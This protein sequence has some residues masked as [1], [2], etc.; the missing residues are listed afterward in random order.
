MRYFIR[1]NRD[2]VVMGGI[3][4]VLAT[5]LFS[6]TW[7]ADNT[8]EGKSTDEDIVWAIG[9]PDGLSIEFMAGEREK[10][11]FI[12]EMDNP[13]EKFPGIH[14]GALT[15][16]GEIR[17][18]PYKIIFDLPEDEKWNDSYLFKMDLFYTTGSPSEI[19]IDIN[20]NR[21]IF[22]VHHELKKDLNDGQGNSPLLAKQQLKIP[23]NSEWLKD[24]NNEIA[25]IPLGIGQMSYDALSLERAETPNSLIDKPRLNPTVFFKNKEDGLHQVAKLE[26]PFNGN[27]DEGE[28]IITI[29]ENEIQASLKSNGYDFGVLTK[30]IHIPAIDSDTQADIAVNL[31]G[32]HMQETHE[33]RAAKK[34]TLFVTPRVHNDVGYTDLQPHVNELDNRNTDRILEVLD[35]YPFYKFNFETSWLVENYIESRT[36]SYRKKFFEHSSAGRAPINAL[37]LNLLTGLS[38]GEELH[39]ATYFSY[40]LHKEEGTNFDWASL[41]D[42]PSHSWFLPTLLTDIGVKGFAVGSNQTRAPILRF[43]NLN[44]KSPFYW[45]GMNGEKILKWYSR[46]YLQL[47]RLTRLGGDWGGGANYDFMKSTV[48]QFL[49]RYQ[50]NS[51]TPDAV[52]MY[53]SYV[54]NALIPEDADAR[55]IEKWNEEYAYPEIRTASDSDFYE[56][57]DK[58][59]REDLATYRGGAGAYWEDGAGSTANA[60]KL[61]QKT[62]EILPM[63]ETAA[64]L[65][66]VFMPRHSYKSEVFNE[67]WKNILFYNEHTWGAYSSISQPER[68]FVTK[69]WEIK[70]NYAE[71]ADIS[72]RT[73]LTRSLNR[74]SQLFEVEGNTHFAYNWQPWERSNPIELELSEGEYLVDLE[75]DEPVEYDVLYAGN[76]YRKIRFIANNVPAMGYKGYEIR[77]LHEPADQEARGSNVSDS[78]IAENKYYKLTIDKATGGISSI[79]DKTADNKEMVDSKASYGLNEYLYV[80]GGEN[81]KVLNHGMGLPPADLTINRPESAKIVENVETPIGHRIVVETSSTNTPTIRSEYRLYDDL[82]R[83]D[84]INTINKE[85]TYDK[86]GVYFAYPF[87]VGQPDVSY[88][89]QNGWVRPN[90]DQLPGAAREWFTT[91]NLVKTTDG[92]Y[93]IAWATPDAPL[94]TLTDINRGKWPEHLEINNGH[95]FSYVLNNYWFTNYKA[96]QGGEFKFSYAI[97]SGNNL[98]NRDLA[99]FDADIRKPVM[100]YSLLST[101]SAATVKAENRPLSP[102]KGTFIDVENSSL[103]FVALKKAEFGEGYILRLRESSGAKGQTKISSS[104]FEIK[105]AYL[106]NGVEENKEELKVRDNTIEVPFEKNSFITVRLRIASKI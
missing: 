46:S 23:I 95:V 10:V 18:K 14:R 96:S 27:F 66:S 98:S 97:T 84:L 67:I 8:V 54:D 44:E 5:V 78:N 57:I 19:E 22:P 34:W 102:D 52:M 38:S 15:S 91:Q 103:Q 24:E 59:F 89:I 36:Q 37:Y 50:T 11:E 99:H 74:L 63:A 9:E 58:N 79:I 88:Q 7:N 100:G 43:S 93:T 101:W 53:G 86:E 69:Q 42:A 104:F 71:K 39:R 12:L 1:R 45:E 80:S 70:R 76:G 62:Q 28:A 16:N 73:V 33:F 13:S 61:I 72:A 81:S 83:I 68:E 47:A 77:S 55:I 6:L 2:K 92:D 64:S 87:N 3:L 65:S 25:I 31:G 48:P 35:Q 82:K 26:V 51:Y 90:K 30:K 40:K 60:T 41:T 17:K 32:I 29:E 49:T 106:T 94:F 56:Y 105:E 75:K 85:S 21:G 20:G 4:A